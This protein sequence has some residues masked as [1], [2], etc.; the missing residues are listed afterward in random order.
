[1]QTTHIARE[2]LRMENSARP[3]VGASCVCVACT[4]LVPVI[5]SLMH[6][7]QRCRGR[8]TLGAAPSSGPET[9]AVGTFLF[10]FA[11]GGLTLSSGYPAGLAVQGR[12]GVRCITSTALDGGSTS[13]RPASS[14]TA[15][16]RFCS[17]SLRPALK[18]SNDWCLRSTFAWANA[19]VR[20]SEGALRRA[21]Y[22]DTAFAFGAWLL[23]TPC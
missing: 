22:R 18:T 16:C 4:T 14:F 15:G 17:L 8:D 7:L 21:P 12:E 9:R 2:L 13:S 10:A 23:R 19:G 3:K 5:V 1:M 11:G 6:L 20:G